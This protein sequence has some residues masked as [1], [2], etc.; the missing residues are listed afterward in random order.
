MN[1]WILTT[2]DNTSPN[3]TFYTDTDEILKVTKDGFYVRG[4]KVEQDEKEA[5]AV[6]N[7]FRSWL[8]WASLTRE[9]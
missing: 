9:Y 7:S 1:E 5:E 6:Y 2:T 3:V 8:V 4:V